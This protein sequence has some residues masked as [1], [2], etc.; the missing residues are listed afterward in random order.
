MLQPEQLKMKSI[1]YVALVIS[2]LI[3]FFVIF[4]STKEDIA[5]IPSLNSVENELVKSIKFLEKESKKNGFT[6]WIC[7]QNFSDCANLKNSIFMK[8]LIFSLL[9][10]ID[11]EKFSLYLKHGVNEI[12]DCQGEHF[13]WDFS[14]THY[15][16]T[17]S[18]FP[19]LDTTSLCAIFLTSQGVDFHIHEIKE[20]IFKN[21]FENGILL[22]YLRDFQPPYS[23]KMNIDPVVNANA[24]ILLGQEIPS[25][26]DFINKNYDKSAYYKD[27]AVVFYMLSKA[28]SRGVTCVRPSIDKLYNKLKKSDLLKSCNTPLHLSMFITASLKTKQNS[29]TIDKAIGTLFADNHILPF[30]EHFFSYDFPRK[31]TYF[32]SP[33]FS[34]A[35]YAEALLNIKSYLTESGK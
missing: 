33:A 24:L 27:D 21:Q 15:K 23:H 3:S 7:T 29:V 18:Y 26:C 16:D 32:Y 6:T 2:I 13:L 1:F 9:A 22:T 35:V 25:V 14:G 31:H 11:S 19:D 20:E 28:Y 10:E 12:L 34:A 5:K 8:A 17:G 30:Q 4:S